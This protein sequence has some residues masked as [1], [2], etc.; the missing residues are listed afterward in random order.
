MY[1]CNDNFFAVFAKLSVY[2]GIA[3][4]VYGWFDDYP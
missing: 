4:A 1:C 2:E 3:I